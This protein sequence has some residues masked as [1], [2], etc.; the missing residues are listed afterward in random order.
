MHEVE[1]VNESVD[2]TR[3]TWAW[4]GAAI[5]AVA[6]VMFMQWF[7]L[8]THGLTT[9]APPAAL[10]GSEEVEGGQL[11][12]F[13]LYS[14]QLVKMRRSGMTQDEDEQQA[15]EEE[16]NDGLAPTAISRTERVRLAIVGGELIGKEEALKRLAQVE[17]EAEPGGALASDIAWLKILYEKGQGAIKDDVQQAL[18]DRHDWFGRLALAFD[19]PLADPNRRAAVK[20]RERIMSTLRTMVVSRIL[21]FL[22]GVGAL[23]WMWTRL[24]EVRVDHPGVAVKHEYFHAF[25]FF[26]AGFVVVTGLS[27][28]PFGLSVE[29]SV[30][31]VVFSMLLAWL[32]VA[33]PITPLFRG[34]SWKNFRQTVGLHSGEGVARE[35][36]FGIAG[37]LAWMPISVIVAYSTEVIGVLGGA[38][39]D[40]DPSGF[41]MFQNPPSDSG[42]VLVLS[43]LSSVVWA[44]LVEEIVFRGLLYGWLR[45]WLSYAATVAL[46]SITFGIIHPY[47]PLGMVQVAA[48]G[49]LFAILREWR[50]SLIAP[51]VAHALH[52]GM[53]EVNTL[54]IVSAIGG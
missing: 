53:I 37:F 19:R 16:F 29:G 8:D 1:Y 3:S 2:F 43:V 48:G 46:V 34:E 20:G 24:S 13:A 54:A 44:P 39:G 4:V 12:E 15:T 18:I 35:V 27:L 51:M 22:I 9:S 41:P 33:A 7:V 36:M 32:L 6:A 28:L 31:A 25:V 11:S 50:G 14:K 10:A 38:G 17:K 26:C 42:V 5:L 45:Q 47:S 30:G 21:M 23:S 52:N 49:V 40:E